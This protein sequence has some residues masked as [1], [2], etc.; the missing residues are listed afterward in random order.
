M[1]DAP[2]FENKKKKAKVGQI[3]A[4]KPILSGHY[5]PVR[6][7]DI[8]LSAR[9]ALHFYSSEFVCNVSIDQKDT[10]SYIWASLLTQARYFR[11]RDRFCRIYDGWPCS[12]LECHTRK[13]TTI[14][15]VARPGQRRIEVRWPRTAPGRKARDHRA[16]D[17]RQL[18]EGRRFSRQK[19]DLIRDADSIVGCCI[20][21]PFFART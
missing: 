16:H 8:S 7:N 1:G 6:M 17:K 12:R 10:Q 9:V 4:H 11:D 20:L 15:L 2:R 18:L 14:S 3:E 19:T 21:A 13:R 5:W